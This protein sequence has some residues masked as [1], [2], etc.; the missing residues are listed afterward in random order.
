MTLLC[1]L[2]AIA[3]VETG[4]DHDA[5]GDGGRSRGAWQMSEAAWMDVTRRRTKYGL[6]VYPWSAAH[7]HNP[8]VIYATDH[9]ITL[10]DRLSSALKREPTPQELYAAWNLGYTGFK[11]RKFL[12][13]R[14]PAATRNAAERVATIAGTL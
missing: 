14:C 1:V 13:S 5:V 3:Q 8:S 7:R 12:L 6:A 11:R 9:L 2:A 4:A 10:N